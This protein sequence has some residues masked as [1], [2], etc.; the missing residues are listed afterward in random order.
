METPKEGISLE[1]TLTASSENIEDRLGQREYGSVY[2]GSRKELFNVRT[3]R[4]SLRQRFFCVGILSSFNVKLD[5]I[6]VSFGEVLN[7]RI[8]S[9]VHNEGSSD[10]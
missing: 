3:F 7:Y 5:G 9:L 6:N 2:Q 8:L 4:R 10:V 1:G